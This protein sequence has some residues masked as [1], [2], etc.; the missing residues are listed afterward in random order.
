MLHRLMRAAASFGTLLITMPFAAP[1]HTGQVLGRCHGRAPWSL[2]S[3]SKE[4]SFDFSLNVRDVGRSGQSRSYV[5][6]V[7]RRLSMPLA[8]MGVRMRVRHQTQRRA[9]STYACSVL[10]ELLRPQL[11][12]TL[13]SY[14]CRL[15]RAGTRRLNQGGMH[16]AAAPAAIPAFPC[17]R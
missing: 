10:P 11:P 5:R 16:Q 3:S 15:R 12:I 2:C 14:S 8:I 4:A 17:T 9:R 1:W 6:P 13:E 7:L